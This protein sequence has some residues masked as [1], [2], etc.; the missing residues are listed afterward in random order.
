LPFRGNLGAAGVALSA[1]AVVLLQTANSMS[2]TT[3]PLL[4]TVTMRGSTRDVGLVFGLSAAL[5]IPVM[6][7]L[8]WAAGR[9][10]SCGS[11]C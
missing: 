6:L 11:C 8:G 3:M 9:F 7:T 2:V 4:L 1:G 10:G 5:E